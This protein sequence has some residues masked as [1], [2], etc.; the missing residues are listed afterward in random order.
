V[1]LHLFAVLI[2]GAALQGPAPADSVAPEEP[3]PA[4]TAPADDATPPTDDVASEPAEP[5]PDGGEPTV[6]P[7]EPAP[8]EPAEPAPA[9]VEPMPAADAPASSVPTAAPAGGS[10]FGLRRHRFVYKNLTALR[11]NPLGAVN[12]FQFGY[13]LQLVNRNTTLFKE[14]YLALKVHTFLNPAFG[15]IGPMLEI[16]PLAILNLQAIY[17]GVGYFRT[18][19]QLQSFQSPN[20]IYSDDALDERTDSRYAT[21]GHYITLAALLQAKVGRVAVRDN[22]KF[23]W[24]DM[25]LSIDPTT[26]RQD[27]VYY[28]QTL[29]ILHPDRGWVTT[30]D[31]DIIYLFDFGLRVGAR[32]TLTHA[33]YR[34]SMYPAGE[35]TTNRNSPTHRVGPAILY[36]PPKWHIKA[37]KRTKLS[38]KRWMN[39]TA[40]LLVQW[41]AQ[42]RWRTGEDV[43]PGVPYLVLGFSFEG[44]F[45][46]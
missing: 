13:R 35:D 21:T 10:R 20:A 9:P 37:A 40:I 5:P 36:S 45:F 33:F 42:H 34:D 16:Q 18:F 15:R 38:R 17:N 27:T 46:P 32:Y 19:D 23:Y 7:P 22:L 29:D 31:A 6:E 26:G 39:P 3:T 2:L 12:E 44:D 28:D 8:E 30:N 11:F 4:P 14:S 24:A 1:A 41:W 25:A 43:H